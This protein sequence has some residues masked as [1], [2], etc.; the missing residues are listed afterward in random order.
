ME[1]IQA[2]PMEIMK[3]MSKREQQDKVN[4]FRILNQSAKK[5][6]TLFTGSSLMEQFPINELKQAFGIDTI[7]YNRGIGGFTTDDMLQYMDEQIFGTAPGA[8]SL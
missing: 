3:A 6:E 7:I 4:R 2:N 8:P 1:N 5:G